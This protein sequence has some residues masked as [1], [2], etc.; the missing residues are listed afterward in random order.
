MEPVDIEVTEEDKENF[1]RV[2]QNTIIVSKTN[3]FLHELSGYERAVF[4]DG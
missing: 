4:E 3:N 1:K 2:I